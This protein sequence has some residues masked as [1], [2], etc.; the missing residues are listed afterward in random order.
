MNRKGFLKLLGSL[1]FL[2]PAPLRRVL[3]PMEGKD[4]FVLAHIEDDLSTEQLDAIQKIRFLEAQ[5]KKQKGVFS[6]FLHNELRHYWRTFSE[7]NSMKYAN[8]ILEHSIMDPYIMNT[9]SN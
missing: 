3:L 9:L 8:V 6:W 4:S 7:T 2:G 5:L 1:P